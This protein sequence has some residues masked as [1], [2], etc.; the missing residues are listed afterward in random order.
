MDL[1]DLPGVGKSIAEKL[2]EAGLHSLESIAAAS[3]SELKEVGIGES[4]AIKI[5]NAA[6]KR[7]NMGFETGLEVMKKREKIGKL[8]T[9]SKEFDRLLGG[10]IETQ[11]IT[12]F[13]GKFGSGKTQLG[14]QLSVNV[15]LPRERGGLEGNAVYIDTENTFRPER[16]QQMAK[17]LELDPEETLKNIYVARAYN[18]DHQMLLAEKASEIAKEYNIKLVVVDSL[19]AHFRAEYTGRSALAERQQKLNRLLHILQ[20]KIA[21]LHNIAVVVTNQVMARPDVLFGDP[22]APIGG[23]IV[24]HTATF[25]VYLRKG[26]GDK[27]IA[28]L[29][30]SPNLPEAECIFE[31][32]VD[33]IRDVE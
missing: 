14:H 16:I 13:F 10:G 7:L 29:I 21:D 12:E 23:H 5:I 28:R 30:D 8:T 1:E 31:V 2:R 24:G 15:Q 17:Y 32:T 20:R 26:K 22:T 19:T 18:S 3:I 33:G 25:R 4:S 6:R 9:G 27:R 11:A